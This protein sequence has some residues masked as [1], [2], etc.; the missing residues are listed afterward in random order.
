MNLDLVFEQLD[1]KLNILESNLR[2]RETERQRDESMF[3]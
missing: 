3:H 2:E 1:R